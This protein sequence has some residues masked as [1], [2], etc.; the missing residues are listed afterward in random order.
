[1][2]DG[3]LEKVGASLFEA[4]GEAGREQQADLTIHEVG[5]VVEVGSGIVQVAGLPRALDSELIRFP[6][7]LF[8]VASSLDEDEAG[9]ILL[10]ESEALETGMQAWRTGAVIDVPVG[11]ALLGRVV[12]A[13]GR[14]L[15]ERGPVEESAR[16]PIE[17]PAPAIIDRAPVQTPVHT[18][19][20]AIDAAIPIG[21]GQREL[22]LG[23]RQTGK[24]AIAVDT[25]LNQQDTGMLCVFC[26]IGQRGSSVARVVQRLKDEGAIGRC[27]V[28]AAAGEDVPGLQ[29]V[30][31]YA[32]TAMAEHFMEQGRDVLV[33]YDDLTRH[34]RAYRELETAGVV[35]TRGRKGTFAAGSDPAETAMAVAARV[36]ADTARSLGISREG[37][38][39]YLDVAFGGLNSGSAPNSDSA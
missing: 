37:A 28:V 8:G 30:A 13:L 6:G 17:R 24:T 33:V 3:P 14:P 12:D 26:A 32:A 19:I 39:G 9:V 29:F 23:D 16:L 15:D 10:G 34:A 2:S 22:I 20:M 11:D 5:T 38:V 1:M 25:I 31:P 35:E 36:Y 4:V 18:G 21:R 7:E 27:I